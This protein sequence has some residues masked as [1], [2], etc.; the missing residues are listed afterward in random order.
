M[1]VLLNPVVVPDMGIVIFRPG[2]SL[3]PHFRRGRMLLENEPER[4][5]GMPSGILPPAGQPLSED[6]ALAGVFDNEAVQGRAGGLYGLESWLRDGSGCQ[7]PH[8]SWHDE[9]MTTLRHAP[10]AIRLCWHCDMQGPS[11][12]K[13]TGYDKQITALKRRVM[14]PLIDY[15]Q[16]ARQSLGI[17]DQQIAEATGKKS[18]ASHWFSNSQWQLPNEADYEKLQALFAEVAKQKGEDVGLSSSH[19]SLSGS[20]TELSREYES[21]S[22]EF[23]E[24]RRYF[25]VTAFVPYTDVWTHKPVQFYPGKHP[26]EKP[27]E[28]LEQI[29]LASS[30]PGEVIADFFMGS[31]S[32]I[33]QAL[34]HG[35][36]AIGVEL[37]ADR[38]NQ[39]VSEIRALYDE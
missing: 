26:F 24:L 23:K 11:K 10:G 17:T 7:W 35:R 31:G 1:R 8:E 37:E 14:S 28:M 21:L 27:A 4:L 6:P 16:Q 32:T 2:A 38:F 20:Y 33:K 36:K 29:I 39:T 19:G 18:M 34:K 9:N 15:F 25:S 12:P 30:K 13:N 3:L 22:R 5:A